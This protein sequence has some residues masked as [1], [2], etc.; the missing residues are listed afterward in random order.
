MLDRAVEFQSMAPTY[1][2]VAWAARLVGGTS[3]IALRMPSVLAMG[4]GLDLPYRPGGR[5]PRPC[6]PPPPPPLRPTLDE[7]DALSRGM[8]SAGATLFVIAPPALIV[9]M[10]AGIAFVAGRVRLGSAAPR[11]PPA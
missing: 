2:V 7:R 9:G 6:P 5:P 8:Q 4:L 11:P 1:Y 10:A 3:E